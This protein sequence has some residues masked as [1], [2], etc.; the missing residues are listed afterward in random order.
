MGKTIDNEES[1][2]LLSGTSGNDSIAN[3]GA[4]VTIGGGAENDSILGGKGND[5]L[6]GQADND[7]LKGG[8]GNIRFGAV[9][10]PTFSFIQTA[11][12]RIL[13]TALRTTTC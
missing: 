9:K 12:A 6:Y 3:S 5:K 1:Y 10:A 7:I 13:F 2:T 8:E 11:T 4:K